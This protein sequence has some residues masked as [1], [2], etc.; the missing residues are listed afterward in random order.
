MEKFS[1]KE[2]TMLENAIVDLYE[3]TNRQTCPYKTYMEIEALW[4]FLDVPADKKIR[5][6]SPNAEE[7][8]IVR[9][10]ALHYAVLALAVNCSDSTESSLYFGLFLAISNTIVAIINLAE[11]GLDYQAMSLIRN[12]FELFMTLIIVTDSPEKRA[13]FISAH[14]S[15]DGRKVWHKYFTKTK[16]QQ[17]LK[18]YC[19]THPDLNNAIEDFQKWIHENYG[20]LSSYTHS[21]YP[22]IVCCSLSQNDDNGYSHPNIWGQYV[23]WQKRIYSQLYLVASPAHNIFWYMLRDSEIDINIDYLFGEEP[24]GGSTIGKDIINELQQII[25]NLTLNNLGISCPSDL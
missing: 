8:C 12:L 16:F 20:E 2:L 21:D 6:N 10:I 3:K 1:E 18:G 7:V 22:H 23:T 15:E 14:E 4:N 11:D 9:L 5:F 13:A 24:K 17:M 25:K 19:N